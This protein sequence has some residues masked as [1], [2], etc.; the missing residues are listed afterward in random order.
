M[1]TYRTNTLLVI[2]SVGLDISCIVV[3]NIWLEWTTFLM[4]FTQKYSSF[5]ILGMEF[6][7][8]NFLGLGTSLD[9]FLASIDGNLLWWYLGVVTIK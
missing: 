1:D 2:K 3:T 4:S 7:H 5:M 9:E 6:V 8:G